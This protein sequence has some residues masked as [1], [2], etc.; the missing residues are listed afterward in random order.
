MNYLSINSP[1]G[2]KLDMGNPICQDT[3]VSDYGMLAVVQAVGN[4]LNSFPDG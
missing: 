4:C 2:E 3:A 1:N